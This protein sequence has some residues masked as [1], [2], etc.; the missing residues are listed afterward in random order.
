L[1]R[2]HPSLKLTKRFYPHANNMDG[3]FV[4][5][6]QKLSNKLAK[7]PKERRVEEETNGNSDGSESSE[8]IFGKDLIFAAY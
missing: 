4:A 8:V 7:T 2:F 6:L 1:L 5:K 3:F